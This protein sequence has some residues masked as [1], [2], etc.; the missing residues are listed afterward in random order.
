MKQK[1]HLYDRSKPSLTTC[2]NLH[3]QYDALSFLVSEVT[4]QVCLRIY[5][6]NELAKYNTSLSKKEPY[7][8]F[9]F[10][11]SP[12]SINH[13]EHHKERNSEQF[14]EYWPERWKRKIQPQKLNWQVTG[15]CDLGIT[16][17][18]PA[19]HADLMRHNPGRPENGSPTPP[20]RMR[21]TQEAGKGRFYHCRPDFISSRFAAGF[22]NE[23]DL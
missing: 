5:Y 21:R 12:K 17:W 8:T 14:I 7:Y 19:Y 4:C 3:P 16:T 11:V 18:L 10:Y 23:E 2:D 15:I 1:I 9:V 22:R 20:P 6:T 13:E